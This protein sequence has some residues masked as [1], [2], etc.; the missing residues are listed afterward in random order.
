VEENVKQR[1][2]KK[3]GM[4]KWNREVKIRGRW[5]MEQRGEEERASFPG[6]L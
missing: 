1:E 6:C 3:R 4:W 2:V 5:K